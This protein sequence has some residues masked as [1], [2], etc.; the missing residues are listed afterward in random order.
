MNLF[1]KKCKLYFFGSSSTNHSFPFFSSA[2]PA[3]TDLSQHL[4]HPLRLL[5]APQCRSAG[6]GRTERRPHA[7]SNLSAQPKPESVCAALH[8]GDEGA[9]ISH[10]RRNNPERLNRTPAWC[11]G[12][13]GAGTLFFQGSC[14]ENQVLA[15]RGGAV[16]LHSECDQLLPCSTGATVSLLSECTQELLKLINVPRL[17]I[18]L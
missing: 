1:F 13:P 16:V 15:E 14:G 17:H 11:G 3:D 18:S 2:S 12:R 10:P 4:P 6:R 8:R 7:A 5:H 9:G